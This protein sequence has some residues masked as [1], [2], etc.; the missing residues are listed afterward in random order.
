MKRTEKR[1]DIMKSAKA[2]ILIQVLFIFI[3]NPGFSQAPIKQV[4]REEQLWTQYTFLGS[5]SKK[6]SL[7]FDGVDRFNDF[8]KSENTLFLRPAIVYKMNENTSVYTGYC[9]VITYPDANIHVKVPEHRPWQQVLIKHSAG[10]LALSHR[11]RLEERFIEK[12]TNEELLHQ[13]TF[14]WRFRYKL[15]LQYPVWTIEKGAKI[16]RLHISNE[17][18]TSF[19][20]NVVVSYFN[21]N[22][23]FG[24]LNYQV[25]KN[26]N[27]SAGFTNIFRSSSTP[28]GY[29]NINAPT[30]NINQKIDFR[31]AKGNE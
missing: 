3:S 23:L 31:G 7:Y 10:R 14:T 22:R 28:G 19:G 9:Y 21:Q 16:L 15:D 20:K 2:G 8:F 4:N 30:I 5:F 26:L 6:W 18:I 25:N 24:G 13:Y 17:I 1:R 29:V 27:I 11:Y 12:S